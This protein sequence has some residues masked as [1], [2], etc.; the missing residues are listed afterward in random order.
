[1]AKWVSVAGTWG[2]SGGSPSVHPERR[3]SLERFLGPEGAMA[4]QVVGPGEGVEPRFH[5][6]RDETI[7]QD[8]L[9]CEE[10]GPLTVKGR[11]LHEGLI[12]VSCLVRIV[13]TPE[14]PGNRSAF[15]LTV[16][17]DPADAESQGLSVEITIEH[18]GRATVDVPRLRSNRFRQDIAKA[19]GSWPWPDSPTRVPYKPA[20]LQD[21]I[22]H[23]GRIGSRS[24]RTGY[25]PA[26]PEPGQVVPDSRPTW[27][28]LGAHLG[29]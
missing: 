10:A 18:N 6:E 12:E 13:T 11:T 8:V 5:V 16:A 22:A 27:F 26:A 1:M 21:D 4:W 20:G 7:G 2:K 3:G 19:G 25:E 14:P 17:Q 23:L 15:T 28:G 9:V 29:G 24:A